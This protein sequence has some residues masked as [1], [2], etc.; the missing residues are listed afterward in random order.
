MKYEHSMQDVSVY[1]SPP[2][3]PTGYCFNLWDNGYFA[4][5]FD[6]KLSNNKGHVT[7]TDALSTNTVAVLW[8]IF[9]SSVDELAAEIVPWIDSMHGNI[10]N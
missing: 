2:L 5:S 3:A 10:N 4:L 9:S 7:S 1:I 6:C 8:P